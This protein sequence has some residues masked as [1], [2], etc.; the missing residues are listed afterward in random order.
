M[1][2]YLTSNS[3]E[4]SNINKSVITVLVL[5]ILLMYLITA[6]DFLVVQWL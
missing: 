3:K 6:L 4:N 1:K 5:I 2:R